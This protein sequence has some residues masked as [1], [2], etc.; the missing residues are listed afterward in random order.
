[1]LEAMNEA[2]QQRKLGNFKESNQLL[3]ELVEKY[4]NDAVLNYQCA[5]SFDVLG[6]ETKAVPFYEKAIELGLSGKELEGALIGLGSTFR[7]IGEYEKSKETFSKAIALFPNNKAL[8]VFYSMT[9]YNL[10]EHHQGMEILLNC[11]LDTTTDEDI[12]RYKKAIHFYSNQLDVVW[13]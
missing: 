12:L 7:T 5:W 6:E 3:L 13:D 11:L 1:M 10:K 8:Q 4:P 2:I 9:L